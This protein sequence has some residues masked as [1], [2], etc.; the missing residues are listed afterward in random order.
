MPG[1]LL[2]GRITR[3]GTGPCYGM[4]TDEGVVYALFGGN[5]VALAE[6]DTVMVWFEQ[7]R[8]LVDCGPG[9]PVSIVKLEIVR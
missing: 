8:V 4:E 9:R 3:G 6:G 5:G 1:D 7:L 2:V